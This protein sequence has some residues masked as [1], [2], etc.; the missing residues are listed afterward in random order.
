MNLKPCPFC[1]TTDAYLDDNGTME[2]RVLH[3]GECGATSEAR[4]IR[5]YDEEVQY[6]ILGEVWNTRPI[7]DELTKRIDELKAE[8]KRLTDAIRGE[9]HMFFSD[10]E[11]IKK[12]EYN[13]AQSDFDLFCL[14][15][16]AP[17]LSNVIGTPEPPVPAIDMKE[18][19][20][21]IL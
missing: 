18:A 7:E 13:P 3:C 12:P 9:L 1:G 14:R 8:N 15:I 6:Q 21:E 10:G 16:H 17:V 2:W 4:H 19:P 5:E 11:W 20:H